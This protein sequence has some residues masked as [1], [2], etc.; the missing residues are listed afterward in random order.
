[1]LNI[2]LLQFW[3]IAPRKYSNWIISRCD[4]G[5]F[6]EKHG[7]S[8]VNAKKRRFLRSTYPLHLAVQEGNP[9]LV[10]AILARGANKDQKNS[11]GMTAEEVAKKSNKDGSHRQV[12][13]ALGVE[14]Q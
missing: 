10:A 13:E 4:R 14:M 6:L 2:T 7:C 9:R 12:L 11:L 5:S 8:H 1:M 3:E